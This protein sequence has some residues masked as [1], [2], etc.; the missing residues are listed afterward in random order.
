MN[1]IFRNIFHQKET[2]A[3]NSSMEL[4]RAKGN[5]LQTE[6][7]NAC[8]NDIVSDIKAAR[9]IDNQQAFI[10]L[11]TSI[12]EVLTPIK[13]ATHYSDHPLIVKVLRDSLLDLLKQDTNETIEHALIELAHFFQQYVAPSLPVTSDTR[14]MLI[15]ALVMVLARKCN[16]FFL[17]LNVSVMLLPI[18]NPLCYSL[19]SFLRTLEGRKDENHT[20][21]W[22]DVLI[23][24]VC[25]STFV[26]SF[27]S[28]KSKEDDLTK[29]EELLLI[30]CVM[31]VYQYNDLQKV[32]YLMQMISS[33]ALSDYAQLLREFVPPQKSIH[34]KLLNRFVQMIQFLAIDNDVRHQFVNDH[35]LMIDSLLTILHDDFLWE[36]I[37]DENTGKLFNNA[38][39]F[40]FL[41]SLESDL[42][43]IIKAKPN[44]TK[45]ML[46]LTEAESDTTRFNAYRTLAIIMTEDE[47]K[48][49]TEPAKITAVFLKYMSYSIDHEERRRLL[50]NLLFSLKS[51]C[52]VHSFAICNL[53]IYVLWKGLAQHEQIRDEFANSGS[54]LPLLI[55]CATESK[56]DST[57]VKQ[58]SLELLLVMTFN[59]QAANMIRN[60]AEFIAHIKTLSSSQELSQQRVA[61]SILWKLA[62]EEQ[63][64]RD[65][66]ETTQKKE[67]KDTFSSEK[68][69][70]EIPPKNN[71]YEYDIMIVS[72]YSETIIR[73]R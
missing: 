48:R 1:F 21:E 4:L 49:L 31:R 14:Q 13:P 3:M 67:N 37:G 62:N 30:D 41:L 46:R 8:F 70:A 32:T 63:T 51:R 39:N 54:G 35:K 64:T 19:H 61:E 68:S 2:E 12:I 23:D 55:R 36:K 44:V 53:L 60:N 6:Q 38:S 24:C 25:S 15:D 71:Q 20:T 66:Q 18:E 40:L 16:T 57:L 47:L 33:S 50:E 27:R 17:N 42:L 10:K 5:T 73:E 7:L 59:K 11:L 29:D 52:I 28:V 43:P 56:F 69:K 9:D 58:R 45:C 26:H 72:S 34:V 22:L 65:E